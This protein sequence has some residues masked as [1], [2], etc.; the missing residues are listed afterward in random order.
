M[1]HMRSQIING[2]WRAEEG[3]TQ[4]IA[5]AQ[6]PS[7]TPPYQPQAGLKGIK[8]ADMCEPPMKP[9]IRLMNSWVFFQRARMSKAASL[10]E[11]TTCATGCTI[12]LRRS[13]RRTVPEIIQVFSNGSSSKQLFTISGN[14]FWS[15]KACDPALCSVRAGSYGV[16]H[17]CI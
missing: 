15:P 10:D 1:N 7:P 3:S 14:L 8:S 5:G 4:K 12:Y 11:P 6:Q 17:G 13:F 16:A 2:S 9:N